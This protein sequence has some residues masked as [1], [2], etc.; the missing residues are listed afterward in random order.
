MLRKAGEALEFLRGLGEA[1]VLS[2]VVRGRQVRRGRLTYSNVPEL[3]ASAVD[4]LKASK[5]PVTPAN[6][7][8]AASELI[9]RQED[10]LDELVGIFYDENGVKIPDELG[11]E[12]ASGGHPGGARVAYDPSADPYGDTPF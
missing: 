3:Y 12:S 1:A 5:L 7:Q 10:Q 8:K 6:V 11:K 4:Y 2:D 9:S